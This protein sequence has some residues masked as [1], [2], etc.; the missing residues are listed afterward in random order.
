MARVSIA[1][2]CA[3]VLLAGV[4]PAWA[5]E[6]GQ[7]DVPNQKSTALLSTLPTAV[8]TPSMPPADLGSLTNRMMDS[9]V[10]VFCGKTPASAWALSGINLHPDAK[11]EGHRTALVTSYEAMEPCMYSGTRFIEMRHRGVETLAYVWDWDEQSGLAVVHTSL[12]IAGLQWS[13][14]PRP[15]VGQ[16]V[17]ALGSSNGVGISVTQG[18]V[19][20]MGL[21]DLSTS[22]AVGQPGVGGPVIDNAGRVLAT[23]VAEGVELDNRAIGNPLLCEDLINCSNP[24]GVWMNFTVPGRVAAPKAMALK[25]AVRFSWAPP[26]TTSTASPVETFEYR[27]PGGLWISTSARGVTVRTQGKGRPVT[28]EVRAVNFV[29]PGSSVMISGRSR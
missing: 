24:M 13:Q 29:G 15:A 5:S 11:R 17:A 16:W 3:A 26:T 7:V 14:V 12:V 8:W 10:T 18:T 20:S 1:A 6:L 2:I 22:L 9:V 23:I 4:S 27:Q 25:S 19:T 21:R 28:L